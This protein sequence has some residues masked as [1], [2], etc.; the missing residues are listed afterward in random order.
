MSRHG[1]VVGGLVGAALVVRCATSPPPSEAS[2]RVTRDRAAVKSCV[3]LAQV[4]TDLEDEAAA[5][6]SL[7]K[8]TADLGGNVLF[9]FN[10]HAGGAFYCSGPPPAQITIGMPGVD[11]RPTPPGPP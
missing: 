4:K 1:L 5:Q 10:P 8:Q 7:K 6:E 9:L 3:D 11:M 2:V